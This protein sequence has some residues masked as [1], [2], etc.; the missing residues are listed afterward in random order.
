MA[1]HESSIPYDIVLVASHLSQSQRAHILHSVDF[2]QVLSS[3]SL[4]CLFPIFNVPD[5]LWQRAGEVEWGG[6]GLPIAALI[7]L[8]LPACSSGQVSSTF[9]LPLAFLSDLSSWGVS[10]PDPLRTLPAV[11]IAIDLL[12]LDPTLDQI[13]LARSRLPLLPSLPHTIIWKRLTTPRTHVYA[14]I[15]LP[16]SLSSRPALISPLLETCHTTTPA[17]P[18]LPPAISTRPHQTR[19]LHC[20]PLPRLPPQQL[21]LREYLG[22]GQPVLE[23]GPVAPEACEHN[24]PA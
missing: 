17:P 23:T 7:V 4:F 3:D 13:W 19:P 20:P 2:D 9:D 10:P 21:L 5:I 15:C 8:I 12:L 16:V 14:V 24:H 1:K 18:G 6:C 11:S 22:P